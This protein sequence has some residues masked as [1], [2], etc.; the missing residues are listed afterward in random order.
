MEYSV[1]LRFTANWVDILRILFYTCMMIAFF[2]GELWWALFYLNA[3]MGCDWIDGPIA[4]YHQA[5]YGW[6]LD[7]LVVETATL[8]NLYW[9]CVGDPYKP[10]VQEV[11][12]S[13]WEVINFPG[14][15][16][17]GKNMDPLM[18]KLCNISAIVFLG[19]GLFFWPLYAIPAVIAFVLQFLV[20]PFKEY[21]R[22][23]Y[24]YDTDASSTIYGKVKNW[25]EYIAISVIIVSIQLALP[26]VFSEALLVLAIVFACLSLWSHLKPIV[27]QAMAA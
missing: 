7:P 3:N 11:L 23:K 25:I 6:T 24:G 18:D 19:L 10:S 9:A 5:K 27:L 8:S 22:D 2:L 12:S 13:Y 1:R 15:T 4:R 16:D 20:R 21:M 26:M 14:V 17:F